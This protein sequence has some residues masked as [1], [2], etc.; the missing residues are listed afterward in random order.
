MAMTLVQLS[1]N[2]YK[3]IFKMFVSGVFVKPREAPTA[4]EELQGLFGKRGD[5]EKKPGEFSP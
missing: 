4:T 1:V 2:S 3:H 5:M